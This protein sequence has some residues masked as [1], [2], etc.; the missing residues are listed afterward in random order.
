[1]SIEHVLDPRFIDKI[2]ILTSIIWIQNNHNI[3]SH[4]YETI[5]IFH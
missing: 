2:Q 3:L 5:V 4:A 1:M